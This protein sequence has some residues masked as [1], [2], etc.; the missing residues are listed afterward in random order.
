MHLYIGHGVPNVGIIEQI[1]Q[2]PVEFELL[3]TLVEPET[4]NPQSLDKSPTSYIPYHLVRI[5]LASFSSNNLLAT[6]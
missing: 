6:G 3:K 1:H 5:S 2:K 4:A